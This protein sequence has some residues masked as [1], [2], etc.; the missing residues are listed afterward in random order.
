MI[1]VNPYFGQGY[2]LYVD[3]FCTSV[4]LFKDLYARG[5]GATG[6]IRETRRDFP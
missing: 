4:T 6:T 1:L 5:V 3:N 2:H